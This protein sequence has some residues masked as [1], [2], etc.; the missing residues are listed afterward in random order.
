VPAT[1]VDHIVPLSRGG[2][3]ALENLQSLCAQCHEAKTRRDMGWRDRPRFG[4]D[5]WPIS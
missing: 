3:D 1:E 5:G 4:P 2:T